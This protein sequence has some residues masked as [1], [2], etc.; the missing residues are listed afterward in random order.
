MRAAGWCIGIGVLLVAIGAACGGGDDAAQ[1]APGGGGVGDDGTGGDGGAA[2]GD[3]GGTLGGEG[4][5]ASC[6]EVG[7][8]C[9]D[10]FACHAGASCDGTTCAPAVRPF[11]CPAGAKGS[12]FVAETAPPAVLAPW[13]HVLATVTFANCTTTPWTASTQWLLGFAAPRDDDP[14]GEG[15]VALPGDVAPGQ[16]V[17]FAIPVHAPPMT[18]KHLYAWSILQEGVAWLDAPSPT[19][20]IDVEATAKT[21]TIC[22]GVT[23]DVG[24]VASARA[25]VQACIDQTPAGGTLEL[26]A[27]IYRIDG[28][29]H[30]DKALTLRTS[31][32]AASTLGCLDYGGPAC[33]VL[34]AD[35]NVLTPRGFVRYGQAPVSNVT[36]DHVILD[37]NRGSRTAS[38]AAAQCA[39]G[40]NGPGMNA[41]TG[42]QACT[43]CAFTNGASVRALCGTGLEWDGDRLTVK[44]SWF[45]DNGDHATNNMW[46]DG[47]TVHQ[48]DGAVVDHV[49]FRDNSDVDFISGG[50]K[51][52][53]FTNN[54]IEQHFQ[55]SFA[56]LMLDNFGGA[57]SGDFT[58]TVVQGNTVECNG[59]LC[60]FALELGPH[61]WYLSANIAGGT[62]AGN[63][64]HGGKFNINVE[65][66]G[67]AGQP[68]VIGA[69]TV[70]PAASSASFNCGARTTTAFNVSSDSH[71]TFQNGAAASAALT[72]HSCP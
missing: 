27:G 61:P 39:S 50:G 46:S 14:W 25:Q 1:G 22:P 29:I 43:D 54:A 35:E 41:S 6:G 34:R 8:P 48:S 31:G 11:S 5:S 63:T 2:R 52:A 30:L 65:G 45:R 71:V 26:P 59:E 37:G 33:V 24:G 28:E 13:A 58:G 40:N 44:N 19:H 21:A 47:L 70:G 38:A 17:T 7:Q 4:G 53:Q 67:T 68:I 69:N 57:T 72:F 49:H 32:T 62:V 18:G 23:A 20:A 16:Q 55:A 36:L 60:D 66:G 42:G 12:V 56:G 51:N 15:R 9:C 64:L 3:D 10:D